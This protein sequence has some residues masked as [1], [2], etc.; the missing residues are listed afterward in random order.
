MLTKPTRREPDPASVRVDVPNTGSIVDAA[1]ETFGPE[2]S[3]N[4]STVRPDELEE[5][6]V[7]EQLPVLPL[8]PV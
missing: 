8:T 7:D 2:P 6:E 5:L 3:E 1:T 4:P